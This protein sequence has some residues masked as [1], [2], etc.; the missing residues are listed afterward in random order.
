MKKLFV[1]LLAL[2]LAAPAFAV[3]FIGETEANLDSINT[4]YAKITWSSELP[5]PPKYVVWPL[6]GKATVNWRIRDDSRLAG[7]ANYVEFGINQYNFSTWS[8]IIGGNG[9]SRKGESTKLGKYNEFSYWDSNLLQNWPITKYEAKLVADTKGIPT[10]TETRSFYVA[11]TV[12]TGIR[13]QAVR[14][15]AP[16]WI[17]SR[18]ERAAMVKNLLEVWRGMKNSSYSVD[19]NTEITKLFVSTGGLFGPSDAKGYAADSGLEFLSLASNVF[20][21]VAT[22]ALVEASGAIYQAYDWGKWVKDTLNNSANIWKNSLNSLA[23]HNAVNTVQ[24]GDLEP[25]LVALADA[26]RAEANEAVNIIYTN[27]NASDLTWKSLL[28]TERTRFDQTAIA[29]SKALTA[30]TPI[31]NSGAD[32]ATKNSVT[33]F[34]QSI[35]NLCNGD[36]AVLGKALNIP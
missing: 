3:F 20:G 21:N 2:L 7:Y 35:M 14:N 28:S 30:A 4:S 29:A 19:Y 11:K 5:A 24:S 12:P 36:K 10:K 15:A 33:N 1:L 26:L 17:I 9:A 31:L 23:S 32:Q 25:A 8:W 16:A 13:S 22:G 18:Y 34:L 27:P 6:D